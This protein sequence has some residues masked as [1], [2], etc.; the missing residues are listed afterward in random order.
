MVFE[1]GKAY[2]HNSG[3]KMRIIAE[4]NSYYFGHCL[5]AETDSAEFIPVGK[6]EDYSVNWKECE[7]F[8]KEE[9]A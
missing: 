5:L 1:V 2:K 3:E 4:V 8:G 7:D 9:T 6:G